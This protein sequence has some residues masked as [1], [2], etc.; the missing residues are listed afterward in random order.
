MPIVAALIAAL[1]TIQTQTMI[2]PAYCKH[3][4]HVH[5]IWGER[6]CMDHDGNHGH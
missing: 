1:I 4:V 5:L 6:P 3:G 2:A